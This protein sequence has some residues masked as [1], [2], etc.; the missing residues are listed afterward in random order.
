MKNKPTTIVPEK[1]HIISINIIKANLD[2]SDRFLEK[3]KKAERFE[4][5]IKQEMGHNYEE[6]KSRCRIYFK[7]EARDSS[8]KPI[9]LNVDYGIEF[10]FHV[11][12]LKDFFIQD[13]NETMKMDASLA[14]TL[15]AMAYSTARG[16]VFERTR[17]TFFDG[18]VLPV[19]DPYKALLEEEGS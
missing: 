14:T 17:G 9:G 5:G 1:I 2:T 4:F 3:P 13:D 15:L 11:E 12:N 8:G 16:I 19:I 18:I 7:L 10:H 6:N